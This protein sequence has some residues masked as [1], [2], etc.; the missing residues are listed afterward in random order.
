MNEIQQRI[1]DKESIKVTSPLLDHQHVLSLQI[2]AECR[3]REP[4]CG[5]ENGQ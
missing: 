1:M 4:A 2:P 5:N 3:N